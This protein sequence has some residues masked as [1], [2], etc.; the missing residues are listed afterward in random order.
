M[1]LGIG[2]DILYL[3][4]ITSLASRRGKEKLAKRI[5]STKELSEFN[6]LKSV[7]DHNHIMYLATR[8]CIKEAVYKALYPIHKLEWKQVTVTKTGGKPVLMIENSLLYGI[9]RTHVS[10]SHDGDYAMAQVI[11][12]GQK[13]A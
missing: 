1:I 12:E 4:R 13:S 8:W 10:V 3:P 2:V 6:Q 9:Q 5:L 11:L 7:H